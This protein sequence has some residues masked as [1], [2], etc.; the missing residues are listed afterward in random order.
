MV[1]YSTLKESRIIDF[2]SNSD[3]KSDNLDKKI[4]SC[5]IRYSEIP[6]NRFK[7]K[8]NLIAVIGG[9]ESSERAISLMSSEKIISSLIELKYYVVFIDF[10]YNLPEILCTLAPKAVFNALHGGYGENGSLQGLLNV[11]RIPYSG[12]GVL[13]SSIALNKKI[14]YKIASAFGI[15]INKFSVISQNEDLKSIKMKKP[16]II[17]P[18]SQGSSIGV[19]V[20]SEN[21]SFS[22][23]EYQFSFGKEIIIEPFIKGQE[24][25]VAVLNGKALGVLEIKLLKGKKF[26]DYETKYNQGFAQHILPAKIDKEIYS[27]VLNISEK[28]FNI[29]Q[30][31]GLVR[32][33]FLYKKDK[34]E[35]YFLEVNTNPG[36]TDLS[37]CPEIAA[38][39]NISYK[40][41]I[42]ILIK[43]AKFEE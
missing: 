1:K 14:S 6:Q 24:L 37:I 35:L 7:N 28:I 39:N 29:F 30:C 25:Q 42:E 9:G 36:M 11:M 27:T 40:N 31:Q 34:N 5:G 32:I 41:L 4:Y 21:Q 2:S 22:L 23:S 16:Y 8:P 12:S 43:N 13:S 15:K 33:E 18:I 10:G 20:I 3:L 26:Y 17:K 19:Q 38:Y